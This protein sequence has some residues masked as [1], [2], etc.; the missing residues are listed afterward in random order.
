MIEI[1]AEA[2]PLD[3]GHSASHL[4]QVTFAIVNTSLMQRVG[5]GFSHFEDVTQV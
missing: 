3:A 4:G 1:A 5:Q 2:Q